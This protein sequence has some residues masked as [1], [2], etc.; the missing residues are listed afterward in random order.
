MRTILTLIIVCFSLAFPYRT[1]ICADFG[2]IFIPVPPGFEGPLA[3]GK[4][5]AMTSAWVKRHT[6]SDGGTLLQ[7]ST[8]EEGAL[9][10]INGSQRA[11][12][13]KKYLL[14]FVGGIARRRDNFTLG[15]VESLSLDGLPAARVKWTGSV[16][17]VAAIGVMY[18]VLVDTTIVSFHTQDSGSE[19]TPA[20]RS[21]MAAIEAMRIR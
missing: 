21:A 2:P 14:D 13:A 10:G 9:R 3:G 8:Y 5:G 16:G 18:C 12:G 15:P 6:D 7:V 20:M 19:I 11:D 1:G 4:D 17:S